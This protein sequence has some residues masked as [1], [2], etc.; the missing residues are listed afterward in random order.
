MKKTQTLNEIIKAVKAKRKAGKKIVSTSGC[1]DILHVGHIRNLAAAKKLGDV[2]VVGINSDA[3]VRSYKGPRRPIIPARER[4][5]LL[6]ALRFVDHVFIFPEK[7][8]AASIQKLRPDVHVKGRGAPHTIE[9]VAVE[10]GGGKMKLVPFTKG[11][12]TTGIVR[13][14][15]G[16]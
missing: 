13:K 7:N 9:K 11:R 4:A 6:M 2:L 8:P 10:K 5:E 15:L 12:S 3:S 14:I 1:F 16:T